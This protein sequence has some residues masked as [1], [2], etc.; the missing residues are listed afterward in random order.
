M[1]TPGA[2]ILPNTEAR[3]TVNEKSGV[4][5]ITGDVEVSPAVVTHKN[6]VVATGLG[7]VVGRPVAEMVPLASDDADRAKLQALVDLMLQLKAEPADLI[8][9]IK[10]LKRAGKLHARLIVE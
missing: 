1:P 4:I 9:V 3:V 7:T 8:A 6:L 5:V 10:E 2:V